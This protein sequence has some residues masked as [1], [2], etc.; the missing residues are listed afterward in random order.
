M[1][2]TRCQTRFIWTEVLILVGALL[3][4]NQILDWTEFSRDLSH[5]PAPFTPHFSLYNSERSFFAFAKGWPTFL[6]FL[7]FFLGQGLIWKFREKIFLPEQRVDK[8]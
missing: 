3:V 2:L 5:N 1:K 8:K 7:L 4:T 6:F